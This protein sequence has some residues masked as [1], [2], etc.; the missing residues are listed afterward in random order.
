M[1][2]ER[3]LEELDC[4]REVALAVVGAADAAEGLGDK[5][6]VGANFAAFVD[7]LL[8]CLDALV[9]VA[10]LEVDGWGTRETAFDRTAVGTYLPSL[11]RR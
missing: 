9:V 6:E 8:T 4:V 5:L 2:G 7:G 1:L 10:L 11:S 3:L